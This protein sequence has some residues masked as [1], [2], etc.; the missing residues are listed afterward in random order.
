LIQPQQQQPQQQQQTQQQ[1]AMQTFTIAAPMQPQVM[2][3]AQQQPQ[4][5]ATSSNQLTN[6]T[7][8]NH[9]INNNNN[10]NNNNNANTNIN[11]NTRSHNAPSAA[12]GMPPMNGNNASLAHA[13]APTVPH[14]ATPFNPLTMQ[15]PEEILLKQLEDMACVAAESLEPEEFTARAKDVLDQQLRIVGYI[16]TV[17]HD[18]ESGRLRSHELPGIELRFNCRSIATDKKN[19]SRLVKRGDVC[20]FKLS[21]RGGKLKATSIRLKTR[22]AVK[23]LPLPLPPHQQ[24]NLNAPSIMFPAGPPQLPGGP[25]PIPGGSSL[26]RGKSMPSMMSTFGSS[27]S[28]QSQQ[29][30]QQQQQQPGASTPGFDIY[31]Q[32]SGGSL[33]TSLGSMRTNSGNS[34]MPSAPS[35]RMQA[36]AI[37][38]SEASRRVH[39]NNGPMQPA[40]G[41]PGELTAR[42][43]QRVAPGGVQPRAGGN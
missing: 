40:V 32:S 41:L 18:E 21:D 13:M 37:A 34:V 27:W 6:N 5:T 36:F 4:N 7:H 23:P 22:R 26:D 14:G 2:Y 16:I 10:N 39:E 12:S 11:I 9:N 42:L 29:Q 15:S 3:S 33:Q 38:D 30:Q 25:P 31:Q 17:D 28:S 20:D 35:V 19:P 24:P 1:N 43:M 8:S